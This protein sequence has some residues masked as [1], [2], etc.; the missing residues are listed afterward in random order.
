LH[1]LLRALRG[2]RPDYL[3]GIIGAKQCAASPAT[4]DLSE[5]VVIDDLNYR[6][7]LRLTAADPEFLYK[8]SLFVYASPPEVPLGESMTPIPT[9]GPYQI[10]GYKEGVK[11]LTLT[12]NPYFR[13]WSF[14]AKPDGYPDEIK[15]TKVVETGRRVADVANNHID[16][17]NLQEVQ[18]AEIT[19][20]NHRYP[21]RMHS[22]FALVDYYAWLDTRTEPFDDVRVREAINYAVD[23]NRLVTLSGGASSSAT[24]CQ[25]FPPGFP[26]YRPYC[27]Y[28]RQPTQDGHY[29]GP[30]MAAAAS[31][32]RA[33][34]TIGMPVKVVS[35]DDDPTTRALADYYVS[36]L[37]ILGYRASVVTYPGTYQGDSRYGAQLG[38]G[39]WGA[40]FAA[41]SNFWAPI[42]SCDMYRSPGEWTT[43]LSSYCN[44]DIDSLAGRALAL[45]G[46]DPSA[47]RRLWTEV[48]RRLT[49]DAPLVFSVTL[50]QIAFVS[51]RVGN[52]QFNPVVGPLLDQ[53][54]V[55]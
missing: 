52:F 16:F 19:D 36:V 28:T 15:F 6:I 49:D 22:D 48:D 1:G 54:W 17:M 29:H 5:G 35:E 47:A 13:R 12:R 40:D 26:G 3:A 10:T 33:S 51:S 43:N 39:Y 32:A 31:L 25:T 23:R 42:L 2:P 7:T 45:E 38:I 4:C 11:E 50:R 8:L 14:A 27:P 24:T 9:T 55:R 37:N 34:G 41:P 30:D 21:S 20:L 44:K 53:I 46:S 18:P